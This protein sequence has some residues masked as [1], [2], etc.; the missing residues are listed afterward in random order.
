MVIREKFLW[1]C[2]ADTILMI[3]CKKF[4]WFCQEN[5]ILMVIC[6]KFLWFC[7]ADTILM[8]I[9]KKFLWF[10]QEDNI[11]M[12]IC[13][14]FLWF[15]Q[16]DNILM[17]FC[18][19]FLW[20]Y[21]WIIF[22]WFCSDDYLKKILRFSEKI[23]MTIFDTIVQTI[24]QIF[25]EAKISAGGENFYILCFKM[26]DFTLKMIDLSLQNNKILY[27]ILKIFAYGEQKPQEFFFGRKSWKT[28]GIFPEIFRKF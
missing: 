27:K 16:E 13:K 11:L 7:Q 24:N 8:I 26:F 12:V 18:K 15:C 22:L 25:L 5:T 17:V 4:L 19:K 2:L 28:I 9:C 6:K 3:I 14:K 10:C 20:F 23:S 21:I 1:F